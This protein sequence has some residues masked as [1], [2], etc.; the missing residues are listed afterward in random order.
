MTLYAWISALAA[1]AGLAL[2]ALA[3][4]RAARNPLSLPLA[5]LAANQLVWNTATVFF[6]GAQDGAWRWLSAIAAPLFPPAALWFVLV[7]VGRLRALRWVLAAVWVVYGLQ[8]VAAVVLFA[9]P[10]LAPAGALGAL[11]LVHLACDLPLLAFALVL[12][13]QHARR[14]SDRS[15]RSRS[16][17][18]VAAL[19]V[20]VTFVSTDLLA[21][22]GLTQTGWA[23][24]GSFAF[25]AMLF[26]LTFRLGVYSAAD[27]AAGAVTSLVAVLLALVGYL[28]VFTVAEGSTARLLV[29]LAAVT[30]ALFAFARYALVTWTAERAGL[31]RLA[32]AGRFSAQ[33]AH[34]LKNPLAAARGA[35]Q[36]LQEEVRQGRPLQGQ[37][38]FLALLLEQLDRLGRVIDRYQKL[39]KLELERQE[40]EAN[41]LVKKVLA[42]QAFAA[43]EVKIVPELAA[44]PL[45]ASADAD[46]LASALENLVKNAL[47]ATPKGGTVWVRTRP[48][49]GEPGV[50]LEVE[51]TGSGMNARAQER[52]FD[53][54]FTTKA[55]GSGLGLHFVRQVARAHGGDATLVSAEGRGTRVTVWFPVAPR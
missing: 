39:G 25:N 12:I 4:T 20:F 43:A 6:V 22:A 41:A 16:L 34:D 50:E 55:Q 21:D 8:S 33:M 49:A 32:L 31:E 18:L 13:R 46:L 15:E 24:V 30:L 52:A 2:A 38:E 5:L 19:V 29:G 9:A 35:A 14:S 51:D 45:P 3:I 47:E 1:A 23:A 11:S 7:F 37:P 54:F 17:L 27:R 44:A 36:F 48:H 42:L 28:A 40:V 10:Q 26:T 53:I